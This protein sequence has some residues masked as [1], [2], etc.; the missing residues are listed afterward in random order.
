MAARFGGLLFAGL[1]ALGS[2]GQALATAQEA[3]PPSSPQHVSGAAGVG[4]A[5]PASGGAGEA[6]GAAPCWGG[7]AAHVPPPSPLGAAF[8]PPPPSPAAGAPVERRMSGR[9]AANAELLQSGDAAADRPP[10]MRTAAEARSSKAP[11]SH[12][13]PRDGGLPAGFPAGPWCSYDEAF[14]A[15]N[16]HT[17][18]VD[19]GDGG[20]AVVKTSSNIPNS[21][22]SMQK[23]LHCWKHTHAQGK[24]K[25][26][27]TLEET[28][29]GWIL[30]YGNL[31]HN[32]TD[33]CRTREEALAYG[34]MR[35]FPPWAASEAATLAKAGTKPQQIFRIL[36]EKAAIRGEAVMF[37]QPDVTYRTRGTAAD[38]VW[39]ATGFVE[40]LQH[41]KLNDG[42]AFHVTLE[43]GCLNTAFWE[44]KG[45]L[46][47]YAY[48]IESGA[49]LTFDNTVRARAARLPRI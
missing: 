21:K 29:D 7:P 37:T 18:D 30:L 17:G 36:K 48:M 12:P 2:S 40:Q 27:L 4:D 3:P 35:S 32:H 24:C 41:R 9:L 28:S 16:E 11:M 6:F 38:N 45:A 47:S 46:A 43:D 5:P 19:T 14:A 10:V 15:I 20:F 39:D 8:L 13:F 44:M 49:S 34:A 23:V 31:E 25:Y 22:R 33:F 42:L 1:R 26:S